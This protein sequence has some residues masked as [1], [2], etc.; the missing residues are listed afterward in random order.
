MHSRGK[1]IGLYVCRRRRRRHENRQIWTYR[2]LCVET[3]TKLSKTAKYW[4]LKSTTLA[5]G[6]K[7]SWF[8]VL[9]MPINHTYS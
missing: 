6:A 9:V 3:A 1:A 7:N 8:C 5:I 2:H 4:L